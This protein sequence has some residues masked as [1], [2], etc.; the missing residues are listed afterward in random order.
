MDDS[1]QPEIGGI[2]KPAGSN[3]WT[4]LCEENGVISLVTKPW[5]PDRV[6]D[7]RQKQ[8]KEEERHLMAPCP[9][10]CGRGCAPVPKPRIPFPSCH[11]RT[12]LAGI[13]CRCFLYLIFAAASPEL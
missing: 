8:K 6:G 9:G 13:Q 2:L 3:S 7:D 11:S 12:F 4:R 5:I 1:L 10:A